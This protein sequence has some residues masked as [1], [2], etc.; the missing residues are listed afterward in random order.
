MD[1]GSTP[2]YVIGDA[3]K[4]E[5]VVS[6]L[7]AYPVRYTPYGSVTVTAHIF[8]EPGRRRDEGHVVVE[9]VISDTGCEFR[10]RSRRAS[11]ENSSRL[12]PLLTT[13]QERDRG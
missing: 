9:I 7:I 6:N 4:V 12:T 8:G 10:P 5:T 2:I 3:R 13:E 1:P 11:S